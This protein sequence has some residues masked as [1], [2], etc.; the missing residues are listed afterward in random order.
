MKLSVRAVFRSFDGKV[1]HTL[2]YRRILSLN[3][4]IPV[5]RWF[6]GKRIDSLL[7]DELTDLNGTLLQH[8]LL[9]VSGALITIQ[10]GSIGWETTRA[11]GKGAE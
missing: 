9:F 1:L 3:A 2:N 10:F 5:Q 6:D 7:T 8:T 4:N 11:F